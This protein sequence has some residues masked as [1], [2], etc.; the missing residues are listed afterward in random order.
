MR[1]LAQEF[2]T[3]TE[4][5]AVTNEVRQAER[6]TSGEIVPMIVSASHHYPMAAVRGATLITLPLA[7][8]CTSL[9]G[10][11]FWLGSDNMYLFVFFFVLFYLPLRFAVNRS[12]K[13]K[14]L[15]LSP[16]EAEEEV[17]EAATTSFYGEGLY[18]TRDENGILLFIS[19]LEQKVWVLGDRGINARINPAE[20]EE[21]VT[22][23]TTGIKAGNQGE[24][25]CRAVR[26]I[27]A[28]LKTH[29]PYRRDDTDELHN[30][31][32]R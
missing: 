9:L 28:L 25:L 6:E 20:W 22:E 14:R 11:L 30:L 27:G 17:E 24:V 16:S 13:L 3:E 32:I 18:R 8:F 5:Q 15:F 10:S 19:V 1:T 31:I 29:F 2:L 4:Q 7:L 23:L 12:V 26:R 21:I